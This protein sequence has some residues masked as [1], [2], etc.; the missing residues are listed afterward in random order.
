MAL[1]QTVNRYK[2]INNSKKL[3]YLKKK[4]NTVYGKSGFL[5][6]HDSLSDMNFHYKWSSTELVHKVAY[7]SMCTFKKNI[8]LYLQPDHA[9][10][11]IHNQKYK[12]SKK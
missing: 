8:F 10:F 11:T 2:R 9:Y 1:P 7:F 12:T 3:V 5:K 6:L 4:I